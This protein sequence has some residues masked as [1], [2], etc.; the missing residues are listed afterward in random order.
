MN[1]YPTNISQ[2]QL[3]NIYEP[4]KA[5]KCLAESECIYQ[6]YGDC[7]YEYLQEEIPDCYYEV[8]PY[9]SMVK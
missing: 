8:E 7:M 9:K 4:V 3:V 5:C 2:K 1:R 6:G